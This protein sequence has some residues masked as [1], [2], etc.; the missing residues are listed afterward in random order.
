[1]LVNDEVTHTAWFEMTSTDNKA[2][3]IHIESG[4]YCVWTLE[5][6]TFL[7]GASCH[8][9]WKI[10]GSFEVCLFLVF[11]LNIPK[12]AA[13]ISVLPKST[14]PVDH[15]WALSGTRKGR[16]RNLIIS[17]LMDRTI[18]YGREIQIIFWS[19]GLW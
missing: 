9:M 14:R 3:D 5:S 15:G 18:C 19:L 17:D 4:V 6:P 16:E 2:V 8:F 10:R 13:L 11:S 1:M 12:V 7:F